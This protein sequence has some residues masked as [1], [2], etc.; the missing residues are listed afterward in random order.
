MYRNSLTTTFHKAENNIAQSKQCILSSCSA[1]ALHLREMSIFDIGAKHHTFPHKLKC[2][3]CHDRIRIMCI[4]HNAALSGHT[5]FKCQACWAR[6]KTNIHNSLFELDS[7]SMLF[8]CGANGTETP[9]KL[10]A[11][12]LDYIQMSSDAGNIS[13]QD[14][15]E[16]D[17]F[18]REVGYCTTPDSIDHQH[19]PHQ[20]IAGERLPRCNHCLFF[21]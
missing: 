7:R 14:R 21:C 3:L 15:Y 17:A 9:D 12:N 5:V 4:D 16:A 1:Q 8:G 13:D 19:G 10:E 6:M 2:E 20:A 18:E 11:K